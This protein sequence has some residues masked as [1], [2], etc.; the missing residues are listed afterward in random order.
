M[1]ATFVA[2]VPARHRDELREILT[3]EDTGPLNWREERRRSFSEF[4]FS[5]PPALAR[6]AHSY[7]AG[8][9]IH[10]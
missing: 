7:V 1:T 4:Y 8:W 3:Q 6:A 10:H 5:G 2:I 9:V